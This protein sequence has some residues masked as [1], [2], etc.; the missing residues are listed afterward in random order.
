[1]FLDRLSKWLLFVATLFLLG[2]AL[3]WAYF[4]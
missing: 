4:A 2:G 1:M 3:Y